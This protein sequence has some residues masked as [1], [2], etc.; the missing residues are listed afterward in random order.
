MYDEFA[1]DCLKQLPE[2]DDTDWKEC[3]RRLS[4]LYFALIQLRLNGSELGE[5]KESIE[6]A[7]DYLRRLANAMEQ[8]LFNE[9]EGHDEDALKRMRSHAFIAAEAIDL[10]CSFAKAVRDDG[11]VGVDMAY[12]RIESALLYLA[13]E[14]QINAHC[15]VNEVKG[16]LFLET[17]DHDQRDIEI[18]SYLQNVICALATGKLDNIQNALSI[19]YDQYNSLV[20]ARIAA[21]VRLADL[22][23]FYCRWLTGS[24]VTVNIEEE[25]KQLSQKLRPATKTFTAVPFSDLLHLCTL[26]IHVVHSSKPLSLMHNLPRPEMQGDRRVEYERYLASRATLGQGIKTRQMGSVEYERYLASRATQRPFLWPSAKEYVEDTFPG[27]KADAIVVVP[28]G[29]GKSFIAE[30]ACSQAMQNGWVLYLAPTNA[31]VNQVQRDLQ[32]AFKL[33]HGIQILSFVGGQEYTSLAG[34]HLETPPEMSVAVMTPEKCAMAFRINPNIFENC[35]LCIVDEFH[36]INDDYRGITLDLCLAQILTLNS[37][38]RL[39]LMSAMVSNGDDVTEWLHKLRDGQ[40]VPLIQIPWRPCRTLRSLLFVNQEKTE[41]ALSIARS[42]FDVLSPT[43]KFVKFDVP[44]GLLGGMCLRWEENGNEE[45]YVSI[46]VPFTFESKAKQGTSGLLG[47]DADFKS[48]KNTAGRQLSEQFYNAGFNVLCFILTSRHH[49]FSSA[50]KCELNSDIV[51]DQHT[52]GLIGLA[53]AE[54]GVPSKVDELLRKGVGVHSSAMLDSEQAAVER[55]FGNRSIRLLFA[56]RTLAQGL[57]LPADIVVVAGSSLGDSR[58]ADNIG[59]VRGAEATILNAFGRAGRAMVANHGLAVLVSDD[60]FFGPLLEHVGVD[61][62]IQSYR[63]LSVSDRCVQVSSPI[64]SFVERLSPNEDLGVYSS[65]ELDLVA[66]L[67]KEREQNADVLR[68]TLG[69]YLAQR[70]QIELDIEAVVGRVRDIGEN[71]VE[72]YNMPDWIPMATMKGGINLLTCWRLWCSLGHSNNNIDEFENTNIQS[73]LNLFLKV[74]ERL[75]PKDILKIMPES[76]RKMNTVLDKMLERIGENGYAVEWEIPD[77]WGGLWTELSGLIWMYMSGSTY[78]EIASVFLGIELD[79][80]NGKRSQGQNHIPAIFSFAGRVLHHLSIYAGALLVILE[81]SDL[82]SDQLGEM[83]LLPLC[84]R[85][86]CNSRDSLAWFRYGYRNRIAAH[87]FAR[88]YPIPIAIQD[89]SE[90]KRWINRQLSEWIRE[91][92][93]EAEA[94][95]LQSVRTILNSQRA[96][97]IES[98]K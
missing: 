60:P 42:Q 19:N 67:G 7:C 97:G 76:V 91:D 21:M 43:R 36:T 95:V 35:R 98:F 34:E 57:N 56:T 41:E 94:E 54:L 73:C 17:Y 13:S 84:I 87:E 79:V 20:A 82:L 4:R 93:G 89:D 5:S 51:L 49:V 50:E 63:L 10:W 90:L 23:K 80:V 96:G 30:L 12:A 58:K 92:A 18:I 6:K 59:G 11:N 37:E 9:S 88:I 81:E 74:M 32:I 46:P 29:S 27:P 65:E 83:P 72:K 38:T 61:V 86:G 14:Y 33:F 44:L 25:L 64:K 45:D 1:E 52:E 8:Y 15:S 39:L 69:A 48:W 2:L 26:L 66:Q 16:Q 22:V 75:P 31:L 3:R 68:H 55:S 28:T 47:D 40:E 78:A 70:Q 53:N 71:L 77:D 24:V 62:V 85:N